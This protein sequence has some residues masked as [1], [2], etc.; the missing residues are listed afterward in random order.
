MKNHLFI[1][2]NLTKIIKFHQSFKNWV[3]ITS[4]SK[5]ETKFRL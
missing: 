5:I 1:S 3:Q 4:I 2:K